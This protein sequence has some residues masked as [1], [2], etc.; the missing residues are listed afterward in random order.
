MMSVRLAL[1]CIKEGLELSLRRTFEEDASLDP[2]TVEVDHGITRRRRSLLDRM[3]AEHVEKTLS[4]MSSEKQ[5]RLSDSLTRHPR[6]FTVR[7]RGGITRHYRWLP[8][9][10]EQQPSGGTD[11]RRGD[12]EAS[13]PAAFLGMSSASRASSEASIRPPQLPSTRSGLE[14]SVILASHALA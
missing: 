1:M 13:E 4:R 6:S 12:E 5:G 14:I 10:L 11:V 2:F 3:E 8:R 7:E 9:A